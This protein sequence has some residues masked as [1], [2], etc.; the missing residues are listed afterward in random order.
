MTL[1]ACGELAPR[2]TSTAAVVPCPAPLA[3]PTS[4]D[5]ELRR[6]LIAAAARHVSRNDWS[7]AIASLRAAGSLGE[8]PLDDEAARTHLSGLPLARVATP[9]T[10]WFERSSDGRVVAWIESDATL[11]PDS[12]PASVCANSRLAIVGLAEGNRRLI[13]LPEANDPERLA[14]AIRLDAEA[15]ANG[16]AVRGMAIVRPCDRPVDDCGG[17]E[18]EMASFEVEPGRIASELIRRFEVCGRVESISERG[19]RVVVAMPSA[20]RNIRENTALCAPERRLFGVES[21]PTAVCQSTHYLVVDSGSGEVILREGPATDAIRFSRDERFAFVRTPTSAAIRSLDAAV[22]GIELASDCKGPSDFAPDSTAFAIVCGTRVDV[23]SLGATS[24]VRSFPLPTRALG[25]LREERLVAL[26]LGREGARLVLVYVSRAS[27]IA[28]HHLFAILDGEGNVLFRT[29]RDAVERELEAEVVTR[30]ADNGRSVIPIVRS[31]GGWR[32][33]AMD[34]PAFH[35]QSLS[36]GPTIGARFVDRHVLFWSDRSL[37]MRAELWTQSWRS[38]PGRGSSHAV[39]GRT[40]LPDLR[41]SLTYVDDTD[42]ER[43]ARLWFGDVSLDVYQ[44]DRR[45]SP[46]D[47]SRGPTFWD[48]PPEP[49]YDEAPPTVPEFIARTGARTNLRVCRDDLRVVPVFPKPDDS[50]VFAPD[51]ACAP[52][53]SVIDPGATL[54]ER[55]TL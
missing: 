22:S 26:A 49:A 11:T 55:G 10:T 20:T 15:S 41:R 12:D 31:D 8:S 52:P 37:G 6:D 36:V 17:M 25:S 39:L 3:S 21:Y 2:P 1:A 46:P 13:A 54:C 48:V 43:R 33:C 53:P 45:T 51:D 5:E 18:P 24:R 42:A 7:S 9:P 16:A 35:G 19:R 38:G 30:Q 44:D 23:V 50:S 4:V 32:G 28:R 27:P 14:A 34:T 47:D 29:T 40:F